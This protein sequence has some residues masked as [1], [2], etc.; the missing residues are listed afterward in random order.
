MQLFGDIRLY[1][2][3]ADLLRSYSSKRHCVFCN[4]YIRITGNGIT[5]SNI[6]TEGLSV[7]LPGKLALGTESQAFVLHAFIH[8]L[9][10][11]VV[12]TKLEGHEITKVF[13]ARRR[14]CSRAC[15]NAKGD[16]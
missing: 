3:Q 11:I 9:R 13:P 1:W 16:E 4:H 2:I 12:W 14:R 15:L 8:N 10:V 7:Q 5:K 6:N